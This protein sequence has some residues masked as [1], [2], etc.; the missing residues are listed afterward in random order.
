MPREGEG[1]MGGGTETACASSVQ[2]S[3]SQILC[4]GA[5]ASLVRTVTVRG[6]VASPETPA[7]PSM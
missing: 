2:P 4:M 6:N 7:A 1:P 5:Y 3:D